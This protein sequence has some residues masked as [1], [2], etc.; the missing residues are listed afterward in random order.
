VNPYADV[1][2][3]ALQHISNLF[4]GLPTAASEQNQ[5]T[6]LD[7]RETQ[8]LRP[9][10]EQQRGHVLLGIQSKSSIRSRHP[11]KESFSLIESDRIGARA[12]LF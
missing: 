2:Q 11:A 9:A 4:T 3:L 7:E 1:R 12:C 6:N 10:N 8:P 5:F